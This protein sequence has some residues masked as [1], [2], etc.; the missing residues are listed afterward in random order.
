MTVTMTRTATPRDPGQEDGAERML[1]MTRTA[2]TTIVREVVITV[3]RRTTDR[4]SL[5]LSGLP[6]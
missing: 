3:R 4:T 6:G 2:R 5:S 1:V